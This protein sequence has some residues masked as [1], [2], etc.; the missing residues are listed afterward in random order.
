MRMSSRSRWGSRSEMLLSTTA[1]GTISHTA[2]GFSSFCTKSC[3]EEA[4]TAFSL[5][6][7]ATALGDLSKTTPS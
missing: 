2:R 6:R 1:A 4:P 7:S 3:S 5:T